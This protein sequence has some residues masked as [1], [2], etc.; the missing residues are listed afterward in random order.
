M[1]GKAKTTP[2]K[3]IVRL[4]AFLLAS[5]FACPQ[6]ARA[7]ATLSCPISLL[8]GDYNVCT[9]TEKATITPGNSRSLTGC[10]STGGAPYNRAQCNWSQTFGTSGLQQLIISVAAA[11]YKI[12]NS[13]GAKMTVDNFQCR[14][15]GSATTVTGA[16]QRTTTPFFLLMDIGADLTVKAAQATGNYSGTFTVTTNIP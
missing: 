4:S 2:K 3:Q 6:P 12:T 13:T 8:F 5:A 16:C 1:A 14:F 15:Q 10:L 7:V 9:S 11:S